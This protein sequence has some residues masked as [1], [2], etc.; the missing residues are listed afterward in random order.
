MSHGFGIDV[1]EKMR[2]TN[3]MVGKNERNE[4]NGRKKQLL[5]K[6]LMFKQ[7]VQ[8]YLKQLLPKKCYYHC[9]ISR[10]LQVEDCD[11]K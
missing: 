5:F 8:N 10:L 7:E 4:S 9:H 3:E 11:Y 6:Q 2:K 1:K